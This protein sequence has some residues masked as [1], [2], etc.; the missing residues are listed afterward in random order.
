MTNVYQMFQGNSFC[1]IGKGNG[2]GC[3]CRPKCYWVNNWMEIIG[4]QDIEK[5]HRI[6]NEKEHEAN[7]KQI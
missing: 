1:S 2:L 3:K 5:H 6:K 4:S 7:L